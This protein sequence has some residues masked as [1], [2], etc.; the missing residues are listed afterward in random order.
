MPSAY[1]N[2]PSACTNHHKNHGRVTTTRADAPS[3]G[4]ALASAGFVIYAGNHQ[5][6]PCTIDL[7]RL[8]IK[9]TTLT[10]LAKL[11]ISCHTFLQPVLIAWTSH[12]CLADLGKDAVLSMLC[13]YC[14][15]RDWKLVLTII[16]Q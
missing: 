3:W 16:K 9:S 15:L 5:V 10:V 6:V 7:S 4:R 1:T 14:A 12:E 8:Y 2:P 11:D 13:I